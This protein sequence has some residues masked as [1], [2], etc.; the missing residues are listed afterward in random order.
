MLFAVSLAGSP[1]LGLYKWR[2]SSRHQR[3]QKIR[4]CR[5]STGIQH[6][7]HSLL[8]AH[9]RQHTHAHPS[10]SSIIAIMFNALVTQATLSACGVGAD[11]SI[12]IGPGVELLGP[13]YMNPWI[14]RCSLSN[15]PRICACVHEHLKKQSVQNSTKRYQAL[16]LFIFCC[17]AFLPFS[18][19]C[20]LSPF[21]A[22]WKFKS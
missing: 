1:N 6:V 7:L 18:V 8:R 22:F 12:C 11:K 21:Q 14:L 17:L 3:L 9:E 20:F 2:P 13:P 16:F 10:V 5:C 15:I 19:L 4:R